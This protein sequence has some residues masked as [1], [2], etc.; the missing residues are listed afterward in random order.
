MYQLNSNKLTV[1]GLYIDMEKLVIILNN[2]PYGKG[3]EFFETEIEFLVKEFNEVKIISLSLD[4]ELT[5]KTPSGVTV[6][7]PIIRMNY[8]KKA[9]SLRYIFS[10]DFFKEIK[11]IKQNYDIKIS[12]GVIKTILS[13]LS[14]G[15]ELYKILLKDL[16]GKKTSDKIYLYSY[17]MNQGAFAIAKYKKKHADATALCRAH[18]Y[19]LY[20]ERNE[21]NY[22]PFRS[23]ITNKLDNIFTISA[24]GKNYIEEK[25]YKQENNKILV[26]RLG[27]INKYGNDYSAKDITLNILSCSFI[28]NIKRINLIIDS[29][30]EIDNIDIKWTHIGDGALRPEIERLAS[31]K[32]GNKS[33]INYC[34][35][36][37][38][39]NADVYKFYREHRV[40]CFINVSESEG[41]PVSMMEAFSFGVPI[42]A[43][44][45]GGVGEIV[46]SQNGHLLPKNPDTFEIKEAIVK[47]SHMPDEEYEA[48]RNNAYET[49]R[50]K[51]KAETNYKNFISIIKG[52][53]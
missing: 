41:I 9:M 33:N 16:N 40:D 52:G 42:I 20:F 27:I 5:R 35:K 8:L 45:V 14:I 38:L 29:L 6:T 37:H 11:C 36:G 19:D 53:K 26:S 10:K 50:K 31:E 34:F 25:L 18:G 47:F 17:W 43:T 32:L 12:F 30:S 51:Y 1:K 22:L 3:E 46:N 7:K 39:D 49:W 4:S 23:Y 24:N 21:I 48:Y 2:Y 15:D 28:V 44:N 13:Y